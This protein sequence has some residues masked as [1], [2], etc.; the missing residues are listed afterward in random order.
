MSGPLS[1]LKVVDFSRVLAGP[2]CGRT[3][4]D[5][6][7]D[8]IK[9][10]PPRPDVSRGAVPSAAGMSGYYAQQNLGKRNISVDLNVP[11]A[12]ELVARLCDQA[13][14]VVENFRAGTLKFF[15]LD[16]ATLSR[17]NPRLIYVSITGYGQGG[18]W[19][20]RMAYAPTV[21]AESGFTHHSLRHF[22]ANLARPQ[23]DA[24]SHADVY[25]GL[26]A[27]IAVL[28]ALAQREKTGRG[29]YI[30]VAMA[31]VILSTNERAHLDIEGVDTGAEPGILGATD[32]PFFTGPG[33]ERFVAAQSLVGSLTFPNYLRAMRRPDLARDP[34]FATAEVRKQNYEA[35][36]ALVQTWILT[37]RDLGALDAQLDES[38]IAI[39]Q[40]RSTRDLCESEWGEYW[41]AVRTVSDRRGGTYKLHGHPWRFSGGDLCAEPREPAFR[42]EHNTQ[43]L[44]ELGLSDSQIQEYVRRGMFVADPALQALPAMAAD[45]GEPAGSH[46]P[47]AAGDVR[48]AGP[49]PAAQAA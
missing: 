2:L 14:I 39:G 47:R 4:A 42:G 36:H 38:K 46:V 7:A 28:A 5:L 1:G 25:A 32:G 31:A 24:L 23:T 41:G 8:V 37:F 34:R 49:D 9:I 3:L 43:V 17:R 18:P 48:H 26:Q 6:G 22:G 13:D 19:A 45:A 15:G 11:G 33:G 29:Q 20:S 40:I 12:A 16:Y 21:Q 35:L 27:T 44:A 10:E 30:D